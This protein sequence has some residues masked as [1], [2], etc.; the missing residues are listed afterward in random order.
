MKNVTHQCTFLQHRLIKTSLL[1]AKEYKYCQNRLTYNGKQPKLMNKDIK[2]QLPLRRILNI[3]QIAT[4][5]N[6]LDDKSETA[7][8]FNCTPINGGIDALQVE[9]LAGKKFPFLPLSMI[10][11]LFVSPTFGVKMK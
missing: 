5:L 11:R 10:R 9:L 6:Q 1:P 3:Q 2:C 7:F 8:N 4:Y